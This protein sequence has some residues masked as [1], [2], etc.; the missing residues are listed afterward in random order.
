M[1]FFLYGIV[2]NLVR[3]NAVREHLNKHMQTQKARQSTEARYVA[4]AKTFY[5]Y[6][7]HH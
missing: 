5:N 1:N 4:M 3:P 6:F 2:R 7:T